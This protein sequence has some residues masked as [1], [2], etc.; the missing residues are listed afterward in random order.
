MYRNYHDEDVEKTIGAEQ[1]KMQLDF[2]VK[3]LTIPV[4]R[5]SLT[6]EQQFHENEV[7][8]V[9]N[10]SFTLLHAHI[11][12]EN[13]FSYPIFLDLHNFGIVVDIPNDLMLV[14]YILSVDGVSEQF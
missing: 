3:K 5:E 14:L 1:R 13:Y 10:I 9:V 6:F 4:R 7:R 12:G 2:D 8:C 11:V